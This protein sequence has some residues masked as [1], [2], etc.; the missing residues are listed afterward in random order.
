MSLEQLVI[1]HCAP[2]L[3]GIKAA[4]LIT[5]SNDRYP[6]IEKDIDDLKIRCASLGVSYKI[7]CSC[8]SFSLLYVYK[9]DLLQE[10]FSKSNINDYLQ[11][12]GYQKGT[13]SSYL[14]Q[15]SAR[16]GNCGDFPHEIGVFLDY[17]IEDVEGFTKNKGK[18]CKYSGY[19]KVYGNPEEAK[20]LFQMYDE[21]RDFCTKL[22]LKGEP[23]ERI[24]CVNN[25]SKRT[26]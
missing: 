26:A 6:E 18:N 3:M 25:I 14:K 1:C 2:V 7:I 13:V 20:K 12:L 19:W 8:K 16:F 23:I 17:P 15:L 5:C 24:L 21:S 4:N 22:A 10:L 11:N 9:N